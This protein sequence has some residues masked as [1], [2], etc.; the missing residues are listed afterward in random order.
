[1][2]DLFVALVFIA[3]LALALGAGPARGL[4]R[5]SR[6]VAIIGFAF[7]G[8]VTL[9]CLYCMIALASPQAGPAE[10]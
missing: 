9:A 6:V 7:F 2:E 4:R 3:L 10:R 1:M 5:A 8:L